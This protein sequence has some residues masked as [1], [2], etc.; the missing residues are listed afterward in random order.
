LCP[1]QIAVD[2]TE[3]ATLAL[4]NRDVTYNRMSDV[5]MW[6]TKLYLVLLCR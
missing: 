3:A 6:Q 4:Q 1:K 2:L 5:Y